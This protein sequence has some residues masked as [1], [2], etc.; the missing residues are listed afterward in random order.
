MYVAPDNPVMTSPP[1]GRGVSNAIEARLV[2]SDD[3]MA[4][5]RAIRAAVFL[6]LPGRRFREQFDAND[7]AAVHVLVLHAG[8]PAGTLRLRFAAGMA[9]F[10]RMAIREEYRSPALFRA[11]VNFSMDVCAAKGAAAVVGVSRGKALAFWRRFGAEIAREPVQYLGESVYPLRYDLT[12]WRRGVQPELGRGPEAAGD[13]PFERA[14]A[15]PETA[16]VL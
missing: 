13:A 6:T 7:H 16:W 8:E 5:V 9:R 14:W 3:D 4:M 10:E 11:L 2:S 12:K 1:N 15:T